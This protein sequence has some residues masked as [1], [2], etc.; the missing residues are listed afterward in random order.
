MVSNFRPATRTCS[1]FLKSFLLTL[2]CTATRSSYVPDFNGTSPSAEAFGHRW[3]Q[4]M[5]ASPLFQSIIISN[6]FP[7]RRQSIPHSTMSASILLA[8]LKLYYS[9]QSLICIY[10]WKRI[11]HIKC[12]LKKWIERQKDC[13]LLAAIFHFMRF[14]MAMRLVSFQLQIQLCQLRNFSTAL[15]WSYFDNTYRDTV[16][17]GGIYVYNLFVA[18]PQ[19]VI[20]CTEKEY[21]PSFGIINGLF[22]NFTSVRLL[23]R[24]IVG[25]FIS[26]M[27][28]SF[29]N[30]RFSS[31]SYTL[32]AISCFA[33]QSL[34]SIT[35][36][37]ISLWEV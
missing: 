20:D 22:L 31:C 17:T 7:H 25:R 32:Y 34:S 30:S 36:S 5:A 10:I 21:S 24:F 8:L 19:L 9:L 18:R 23:C 12:T 26:S 3:N 37:N 14:F 1:Y 29:S 15:P 35:R 2:C 6:I 4:L 16:N 11:L 27:T 33:K 13:N 28:L